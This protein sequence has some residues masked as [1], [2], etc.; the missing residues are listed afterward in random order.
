MLSI[1]L[2]YI[3][4]IKLRY[5]PSFLSF[6]R[7]FIMKWCWIYSKAFPAS[8]EMIKWFMSLLLLMSICQFLLLFLELLESCSAGCHWCWEGSAQHVFWE[9]AFREAL[10][11][12]QEVLLF[13]WVFWAC[14]ALL[15]LSSS[16]TRCSGVACYEVGGLVL[17]PLA[18]ASS[19][20][21]TMSFI[22]DDTCLPLTRGL[23]VLHSQ[24]FKGVSHVFPCHK[25]LTCRKP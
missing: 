8:I 9:A 3:S 22:S 4:F 23:F 12:V 1:G 21:W 17:A 19:R 20:R 15:N 14:Q 18:A 13:F 16:G 11:S 6:L 5:I 2:S 24:F 10:W 25:R 7:A